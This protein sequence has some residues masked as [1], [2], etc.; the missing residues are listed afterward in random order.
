[1]YEVDNDTMR[2]PRWWTKLHT[3]VCSQAA[4]MLRLIRT[5]TCTQHIGKKGHL[6]LS[7]QTTVVHTY[8]VNYR[9]MYGPLQVEGSIYLHVHVNTYQLIVEVHTNVTVMYILLTLP[10]VDDHYINVQNLSKNE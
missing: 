8:L 9:S 7:L 6:L 4:A 10:L 5:S 3:Y 1:M 2:G